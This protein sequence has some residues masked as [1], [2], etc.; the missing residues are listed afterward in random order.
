MRLPHGG[1]FYFPPKCETISGE[2]NQ[3]GNLVAKVI[4]GMSGE[5]TALLQHIC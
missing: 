1:L 5:S 2:I 3:G 4:V